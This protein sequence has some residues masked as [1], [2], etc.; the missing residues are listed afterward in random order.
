[1]NWMKGSTLGCSLSLSL[2]TGS[3][4]AGFRTA[5]TQYRHANDR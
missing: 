1:M 3:I 2:G 4:A 5:E